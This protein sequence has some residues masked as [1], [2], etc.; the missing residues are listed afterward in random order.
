[1][2]FPPIFSVLILASSALATEQQG[3]GKW[4]LPAIFSNKDMMME[5]LKPLVYANYLTYRTSKG[6]RRDPFIHPQ[7]ATITPEYSG[8]RTWERL[9]EVEFDPLRGPHMRAFIDREAKRVIFAF[10]GTC[11]D[12]TLP[13]CRA[14][15]HMGSGGNPDHDFFMQMAT[16]RVDAAMEH[17]GRGYAVLVTGHSLG[18]GVAVHA[19]EN[20]MVD[21]QTVVMSGGR[22]R[23]GKKGSSVDHY[24]LTDSL[25]LGLHSSEL[26]LEKVGPSTMCVF[27]LHPPESCMACAPE[28][29]NY[30]KKRQQEWAA[31]EEP[32]LEVYRQLEQCKAK[33]APA[34]HF[35]ALCSEETHWLD[36][37]SL[38]ILPKKTMPICQA[39]DGTRPPVE[40]PDAEQIEAIQYAETQAASVFPRAPTGMARAIRRGAKMMGNLTS[41]ASVASTGGGRVLRQ[42]AR[43]AASGG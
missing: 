35:K 39:Y 3:F 23:L 6:P 19:C 17:L 24:I 36:R 33:A 20:A 22:N 5:F 21:C 30:A 7:K 37:W 13:G 12:E 16:D 28:Y 29:Y 31:P 11:F 14:D 8:G 4:D 15:M 26:N 42:I 38:H 41:V 40:V 9:H 34:G 1:M 25:D 2:G 32:P 18:A 27:T 43:A 10:R